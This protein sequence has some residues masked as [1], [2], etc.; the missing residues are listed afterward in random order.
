MSMRPTPY[1]LLWLMSVAM[2]L[3]FAT[4]QTLLNNF[5]VDRAAFDGADIGLLQSV[6]EV[7]GFLAF[8]VVWVLMFMRE[9]TLALVSLFLLGLGV[10]VT[11]LFPSQGGLLLTTFIMSTGF[12]YFETV[13]NS[14]ALQ[15]LSK[16]EAPE[17]LGRLLSAG[18]LASLTVYALMWGLSDLAHL[19]YAVLYAVGGGLCLVIT[20]YALWRFPSFAQPHTQH[21][22][23]ILRRRYSLYYALTFMAGARR[24][25]FIVFAGFLMVE[26][27]GFSVAEIALLFMINHVFNLLFAPRIGAMIGRIGERRALFIEY[28]GLVAIFV[29]YALVEDVGWAATL[30]VADHLFF[31]LSIAI[32]TYFQK[33]ADPKDMAATS[34][35]AFTINHIAAVVIPVLFG[36]IWLSEPAWVFLSGAIMAGVSLGLSALIPSQPAPGRE[37]RL[38]GTAAAD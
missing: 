6:R 34:G 29:G 30:Y 17:K 26:K 10:A 22:K 13:K 1:R 23:L 16:D 35:V 2:P 19:D 11:G 27:F 20:L 9:Q 14:L 12:H 15:W 24:Q 4:W 5:V 8:T 7:P 18:S 31:A 36:L 3:A 25:I 32:K 21:R 28:T 38:A 37:W 33:I